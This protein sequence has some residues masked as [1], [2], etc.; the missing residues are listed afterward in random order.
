MP[1]FDMG[2]GQRM[3]AD[4]QE[5]LAKKL[6]DGVDAEQRTETKGECPFNAEQLEFLSMVFIDLMVTLGQ[7]ALV[8]V[9]YNPVTE[10]YLKW[11]AGQRREK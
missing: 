7:P 8:M 9:G 1:E 2:E 4:Q 6:I 10:A 5:V 3:S 11:S